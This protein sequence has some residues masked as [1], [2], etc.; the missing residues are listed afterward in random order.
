MSH[1]KDSASSPLNSFFILPSLIALDK[2]IIN[3]NQASW[4]SMDSIPYYQ[5]IITQIGR[6]TIIKTIDSIHYGKGVVSANMNEFWKDGSLIIT[7]DEQLGLIKRAF[8]KELPFQKRSQE[9]FKKM[10]LK[11][12][13]SNYK[14]S[15]LH[16]TDTL[17]NNSWVIGYEEE[18]TH[19]YFFVL[20]T[21]SKTAAATN[22]SVALLKKILLQQGFLQ[23][24]R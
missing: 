8:F 24:L 16:A 23:G 9:I 13:N 7:A 6:Q 2:G 17:T 11:E 3:H 1:Y 20:H 22:N 5:N 21:T 10:I 4:A 18:N 12:D 14:L 19:I 15:Y